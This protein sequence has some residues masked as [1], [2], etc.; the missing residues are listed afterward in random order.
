MPNIGPRVHELRV[1]DP[2]T[3][4]TWRIFYRVDRAAIL[5]IEW[6]A[7]KTPRTPKRVIEICKARLERYDRA[8]MDD[9]GQ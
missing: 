8:A 4:L 3:R 9:D 2:E 7:K 6:F 1:R 5:V